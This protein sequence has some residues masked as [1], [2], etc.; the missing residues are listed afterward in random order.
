MP[1]VCRCGAGITWAQTTEGEKLPIDVIA[2]PA[3]EG[4]YRVIDF[5]SSP[6]LVEPVS[7]KAPVAAYPDHRLTCPRT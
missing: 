2:S 1:T 7:A 6:W 5:E 3:G 4:R